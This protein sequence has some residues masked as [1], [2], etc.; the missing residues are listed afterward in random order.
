MLGGKSRVVEDEA[1]PGALLL[2]LEFDDGID[3]LGPH[4]DVPGLD[5]SPIRHKLDEP[6]RNL[7]AE[8]FKRAT[9]PRVRFPQ[10]YRPK[11]R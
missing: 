5:N 10:E 7:P 8:A 1:C 4:R 3:S 2:E 9:S 11:T 6:S